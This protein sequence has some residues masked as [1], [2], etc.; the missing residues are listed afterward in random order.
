MFRTATVHMYVDL[1]GYRKMAEETP[2]LLGYFKTLRVVRL[3]P[4]AESCTDVCFQQGIAL[5][6]LPDYSQF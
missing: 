2:H 5:A 4:E 6:L 1:L 3:V